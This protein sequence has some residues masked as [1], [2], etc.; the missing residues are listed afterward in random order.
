VNTFD[1]GP[2][3]I[4]PRRRAMAGYWELAR[5]GR[6]PE[7]GDR[8]FAIKV[9]DSEACRGGTRVLGEPRVQMSD[10]AVL[11]AVAVR[12][13]PGGDSC[14]H[15]GPARA[16]VTLPEPLGDRAVLDAGHLPLRVVVGSCQPVSAAPPTSDGCRSPGS[17]R[18]AEPLGTLVVTQGDAS[19]GLYIDGAYAYL[20]VV[21]PD[22][23]IV[24]AMED[25]DYHVAKELARVA[26]PAGLYTIRTYVQPCD[27]NC[28]DLD[29][30]T[31]ACETA[32]DMPAAATIDIHIAR[33][34]GK[35]CEITVRNA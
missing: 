25:R 4:F 22:G 26:L 28:S 13:L 6:P 10:D 11:V 8:S 27:G 5:P 34:V 21:D 12:E 35:P 17:R 24:N 33:R 20:E 18:M 15:G 7:P 31:D 29:A 32:V 30:P 3:A 14:P 19:G 16:T 9:W 1:C 2:W 23:E